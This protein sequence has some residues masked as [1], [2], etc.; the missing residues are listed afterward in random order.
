MVEQP[1]RVIEQAM[2]GG[3]DL[4]AGD[5]VH[6]GKHI[7]RFCDNFDAGAIAGRVFKVGSRL[8]RQNRVVIG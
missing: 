8:W 3:C 2:E 7:D 5:I 4:P 6:P 1:A